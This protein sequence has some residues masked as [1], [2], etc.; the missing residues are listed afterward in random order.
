M[1][2]IN[3][4]V[5]IVDIFKLI[6]LLNYEIWNNYLS[7]VSYFLLILIFKIIFNVVDICI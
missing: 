6:I 1:E 7:N 5:K 4:L 2:K 3:G